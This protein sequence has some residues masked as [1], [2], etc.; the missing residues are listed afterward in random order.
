MRRSL[1]LLAASLVAFAPAVLAQ[2]P[3]AW[4]TEDLAIF[5]QRLTWAARARLDTMPLGDAIVAMG[6]TFIGTPYQAATLEQPGAERLVVNLHGLDCVTFVENV[7]ALTW[8]A[9]DEPALLGD[10]ARA[11]ARFEQRL[12]ELRYR[13]GAIDGYASRLHYFTEW[14]AQGEARGWWRLVTADLGGVP[15][16]MRIDFMSTHPGAYPALADTL[17][18][19]RITAVEQQLSNSGPVVVLP[20]GWIDA[21]VGSRLQ[22]GDIIAATSSRAGLDVVHTGF[23]VRRNG[24]AWLLHAPLAGGNVE[25]SSRPVG[26]RLQRLKAQSGIIVARPLA[27]ATPDGVPAGR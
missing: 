17:V 14:L 21:E 4:S 13:D 26:D 10:P 8:I 19:A 12:R 6:S 2:A 5:A 18:A 20:K 11:R 27:P 24:Q 16:W 9:H 15:T 3:A 23:V 7:L 22:S 1:P 25:L